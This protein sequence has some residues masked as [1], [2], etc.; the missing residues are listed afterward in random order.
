[1]PKYVFRGLLY[2]PDWRIAPVGEKDSFFERAT[3]E[4]NFDS[5]DA[6][7]LQARTTLQARHPDHEISVGDLITIER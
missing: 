4:G 6:A 1:M 7:R 2:P 5:D 3:V